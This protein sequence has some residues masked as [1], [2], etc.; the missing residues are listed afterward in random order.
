MGQEPNAQASSNSTQAQTLNAGTEATLLDEQ[1]KSASSDGVQKAAQE[2][3]CGEVGSEA[4]VDECRDRRVSNWT[5][6]AVASWLF[7]IG[8]EQYVSTFRTEKI[9]GEVLLDCS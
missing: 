2:V 1:A 5:V 8:L 4:V 9:S 6:E 7:K 3:P